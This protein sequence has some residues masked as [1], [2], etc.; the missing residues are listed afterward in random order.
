MELLIRSQTTSPRRFITFSPRNTTS[1]RNPDWECAACGLWQFA[2]W[3]IFHKGIDINYE[4]LHLFRDDITDHYD[5]CL[6]PIFLHGASVH[7]MYKNSRCLIIHSWLKFWFDKFT[8]TFVWRYNRYTPFLPPCSVLP[9]WRTETYVKALKICRWDH[10]SRH[11]DVL[12]SV[13]CEVGW[14]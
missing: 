4:F 1:F 9:N 10:D 6:I 7:H 2:I 3:N 8:S 5:I 12:Q 14:P 11:T 13:F